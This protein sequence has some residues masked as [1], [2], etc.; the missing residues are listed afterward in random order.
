MRTTF[1]LSGQLKL[2][3]DRGTSLSI[4]KAG[5]LSSPNPASTDVRVISPANHEATATIPAGLG[6]HLPAI[7][8]DGRYGYVANFAS[9]G[10][11]VFNCRNHEV[12]ETISVGIYPHFFALS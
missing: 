3:R 5:G 7:S 11:T 2:G 6:A 8:A 4:L 9:D 1:P 12:V 10:L